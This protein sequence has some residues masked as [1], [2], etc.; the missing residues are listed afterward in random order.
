MADDVASIDTLVPITGRRLALPP[1]P[2]FHLQRANEAEHELGAFRAWAGYKDLGSDVATDGQVLFQH[3]LSFGPSEVSGRT[4][5][6][7]HL[8]HVHIVIPSSGLGVFSYDGVVTEAAPGTVINQHGGTIHDQFAYSYAPASH[9]ENART[10]LS[11][12]PLDTDA[13]PQSFSFLELFVPGHIADVEVVAPGAVGADEQA[14]A[15]DHDYHAPDAWFALQSADDADAAW[16]PAAGLPE[17]KVRDGGTWAPSGRLVA[18]LI[19]A[20]ADAEAA[21]EPVAFDI[22]GETGGVEIFF[23]VAG[24]VTLERPDNAALRLE[25]GD[26]LTCTAGLAGAPAKPSEDLRLLR[27][28]V[29]ARAET[30]W[31]RSQEEI[32]ELHALGPAIIRRKEVRAE[33]D[34]RPINFLRK[35]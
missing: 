15:W 16:R 25:A 2:V 11:V 3:V 12:D 24:A 18:T 8:A 4:G 21:G 33:G 17:F 7:C 23:V 32:D 30:L 34:G 28:F 26:C 27:F 14:S 10:P 35:G 22:E 1:G 20:A 6:H 9:E 31:Q 5:I 29:S 19:L 13:A